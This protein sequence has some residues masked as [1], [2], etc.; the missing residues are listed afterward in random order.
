MP[1]AT[2]KV[3][4][5]K[6]DRVQTI[7]PIKRIYRGMIITNDDRYVRIMEFSP[8]NFSLR[9]V[10]E[11]NNIIYLFA[12]WLRVAPVKLQFKVI[13]R[14]ADTSTI[15]NNIRDA[16]YEETEEK[17]RALVDDHIE[18]IRSLAGKE[19]LTRRYFLAFEYE[20]PTNRQ[21][22]LDEIADELE[23]VSQKIRGGLARCG[24]EVIEAA[25]QDFFQAEILYTF[26]NRR[27]CVDEEFA[28]RVCRV[29][30]DTMEMLG[31]KE[32]VDDYPDIPIVDY[33]APRGVDVTHPDY[34]IC[35]GLYH[36]I[37]MVTKNGYPIQV[38]AGWMST[39]IETGDGIDVDVILRRENRVTA[40]E[41]VALKLKLNRIKVS[42]RS[43]IDT[44]FEE[45]QGAIDAARYI[46]AMLSSGED[47]YRIC[48]F[49][50]VS[51][52]TL[53]E[54]NAQLER[55]NDYL[56]SNDIE[57]KQIKW[58][59][60][61]A[62]QVVTPTLSYKKELF[63]LAARN[64][65][66]SGAAST[67]MFTSAEICDDYGI[68]MG[69][70][71]RYLS[72]VNM[73][74]FNTRKYKNAN[75]TIVGTSGAGKTYTELLMALRMRMQR[76]Q[77]FIISP[78]KAHE[79]RRACA[80]INGSYIRISPGSKNCINIME[81]RPVVNPIA[82]F[83]D[84]AD[85]TEMDSW[86]SQKTTQLLTFFH[87]LINDL[88]NEEE[89]LIDEAIIK[90]YSRYGI[91]HDNN[92]IFRSD[93]SVK[94][95]PII[96]D[97]HQI[98]RERE[99]TRRVSNILARFVSGSAQSFNMRT[100][101]DLD[102]KFIVFD[103]QDLTGNLKAIGMFV[104]MDFLWSKIKEDRTERKAVFID[105]AWQLIGASTDS[106]VADFVYRIFKIVRG[107]GGSAILATQDISDLFSYQDGKFGKAIL[108][109]SKTKIILQ[110]EQGEAEA[111]QKALEL[112]KREVRDIINFN[113][114]E[115][116]VCANN[117]K[118]PISIRA[119]RLEHELITT[120]PSQLRA[121]VE[122]R[123][124][125]AIQSQVRS[126][127]EAPYVDENEQLQVPAPAYP[128][129]EVIT[130]TGLEK[131]MEDEQRQRNK[132]QQAEDAA[133]LG[134]A[135]EQLSQTHG[136]KNPDGSDDPYVP[137]VALVPTD[138]FDEAA[139]REVRE[140]CEV[141]P[142]SALR[143]PLYSGEV[144]VDLDAAEDFDA[145]ASSDSKVKP[146]ERREQYER[147]PP[148]SF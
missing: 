124:Q 60:E 74:I 4:E 76:I 31:L 17:C 133:L 142:G 122:K 3:K 41:R 25:N 126:A 62:L 120:D 9:S 29:T 114:G 16:S 145:S 32:G 119:S 139:Q 103:L 12:A 102:N 5:A 15:I 129:E 107:Y 57:V 136:V 18:F 51:A 61:D 134:Q 118:V 73:D 33:I 111:I 88:S 115:A 108:S 56:Y 34:Y 84:E 104:V 69:V 141:T 10:E 13:T 100:N 135:I 80:H 8:I 46:K 2:K 6:R 43:D 37:L 55:V 52:S 137:D 138:D 95:M 24:N 72:L 45:I 47:L 127:A 82:E 91:T 50:T 86:L 85:A 67:Y 11:Q 53:E 48:T 27:S 101:V 147:H 22:S 30:H 94:M 81:I 21:R 128:Q 123:K 89:Q 38:L 7:I 96:G 36:A 117:N 93:G 109:N 14:R 71:R 130:N 87:L 20:P 42:G 116:L 58:R 39:L 97:L 35:D 77:T 59:L 40:K 63:D 65:M 110:L 143:H 121:L 125:E 64:I 106:R 1:R 70:N 83:L 75:I 146:N 105:E 98:L 131:R 19:A 148:A 26:Y 79:F 90:T 132:R 140:G 78:D 23:H 92:S 144:D 113:R 44:D 66:T 54:L 68:V 99:E 28:D 49:I 112:T